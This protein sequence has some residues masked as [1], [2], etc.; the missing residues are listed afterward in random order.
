MNRKVSIHK[1]PSA[2]KFLWWDLYNWS[3]LISIFMELSSDFP[4]KSYKDGWPLPVQ[5]FMTSQGKAVF[6]ALMRADVRCHI[7]V[8]I[9][10]DLFSPFPCFSKGNNQITCLNQK[11]RNSQWLAEESLVPFFSS[12][13]L[14]RHWNCVLFP[15]SPGPDEQLSL[16]LSYADDNITIRW[17]G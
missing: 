13:N 17:R 11:G 10:Y 16:T 1:A 3:S 7:N 4:T 15:V 9:I 6:C 5:I 14:G 8:R 2:R 12:E